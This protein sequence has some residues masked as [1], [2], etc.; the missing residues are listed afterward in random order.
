MEM[1][2]VKCED[3][4]YCVLKQRLENQYEHVCIFV[5]EEPRV[6]I[7]RQHFCEFHK[8]KEQ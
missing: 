5:D 8:R 2:R 3:C 4:E 1:K 6:N 7:H